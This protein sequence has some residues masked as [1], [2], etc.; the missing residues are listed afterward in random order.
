VICNRKYNKVAY[1]TTHNAFNSAE[2][3]FSFPNQNYNITT[4]LNDGVRGLMIDVYD[5]FGT[6]TVY[7][8]SW[9]LGSSPLIDF[10]NEIKTFMDNNPNEIIT[11]IFE[12]YTNADEIEN[13]FVQSGLINYVYS[14]PLGSSWPTLQTMINNNTRLVVLTDVDDANQS[15][16]WYHYMWDYSVETHYS[17]STSNDFSCD[18]NR[19][20]SINDLFI[21]NHFITTATGGSESDA[22]IVNANPYFYNR[23]VQ[24]WQEKQKFPN[25][26]TVDF[27]EQGDCF[28]LI[29]QINNT[30]ASNNDYLNESVINIYPNPSSSEIKIEFVNS[31]KFPINIEIYNSLGKN[32]ESFYNINNKRLMI[33]NYLKSDFYTII[34][35]DKNKMRFSNKF[36][37]Q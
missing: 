14:H 32:V 34:V 1:L 35:T 26:I 37:V 30:L 20:D 25:F 22:L 6:P 7:H 10:L 18:F 5:L 23:I 27:Y 11:I 36:I 13:D 29:N 4:Q 9:L 8:G 21:F 33:F 2:D 17:A 15:Q 3:N 19:G 28:A 31:L 12:C 24:C 16:T